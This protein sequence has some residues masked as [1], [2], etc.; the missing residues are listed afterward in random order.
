MERRNLLVSVLIPCFNAE[1]FLGDAVESALHQI[2]PAVE[3]IVIDDG[4]TDES[5]DVIKSFGD[6]IRWDTGPNRGGN[7]ARNRGIEL[8][9][10]DFIQFLDADDLLHRDKLEIQV[11]IAM[12]DDQVITYCDYEYRDLLTSELIHVHSKPN[13]YKNSLQFV[14]NEERL[15]ISAP[16]HWRKNLLGVGGF[17]EH[18]RCGQEYDLHLRLVA[19]GLSFKHID[20]T[21]FTVRRRGGSVSSDYCK[22][23]FQ[24]EEILS[25]LVEIMQRGETLSGEDRRVIAGKFASNARMLL[26]FGKYEEA[27]EYFS[28]ASQLEPRGGIDVAYSTPARILRA[29]FGARITEFLVSARRHLNKS[30]LAFPKTFLC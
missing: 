4:S 30:L 9:R 17:R 21:L 27:R 13:R 12:Q 10:G 7:A 28:L 19:Q 14:L 20:R 26:R 8:A 18:L 25:N 29:C 23:L 1:A 16:L 6:R 3:V 24:H 22:V 15:T 5:L 2:Y 11:P